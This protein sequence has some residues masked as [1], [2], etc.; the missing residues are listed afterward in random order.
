MS[1]YNTKKDSRLITTRSLNFD[2]VYEEFTLLNITKKEI[3]KNIE[4][5][6]RYIRIKN[7]AVGRTNPLGI[8][9]E[10]SFVIISIGN[11]L[12]FNFVYFIFLYNVQVFLWEGILYF[13]IVCEKNLERII[14]Y[15][16]FTSLYYE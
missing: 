8:I 4:K 6:S 10:K 2:A 12:N 14:F 7:G 16:R 1:I 13:L 9:I 3:L 15:V 11:F 5:H